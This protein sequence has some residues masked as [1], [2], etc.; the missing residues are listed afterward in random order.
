MR[1]TRYNN[2]KAGTSHNAGNTIGDSKSYRGPVIQNG[3]H[4]SQQLSIG[5]SGHGNI[6]GSL[7]NSTKNQI[8]NVTNKFNNRDISPKT[9]ISANGTV[10]QGG[11]I[12][13]GHQAQIGFQP[14]MTG[15]NG[16]V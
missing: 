6:I 7:P 12:P 3:L 2:N 8:T 15:H 16:R 10:T 14:N 13:H 11:I 4:I 5:N 1:K 9:V